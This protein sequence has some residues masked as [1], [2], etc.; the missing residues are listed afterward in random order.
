MHKSEIILEGKNNGKNKVRKINCPKKWEEK[1]KKMKNFGKKI[2]RKAKKE[3]K[4]K[5]N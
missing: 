4:S 5:K 3:E 1:S 2:G